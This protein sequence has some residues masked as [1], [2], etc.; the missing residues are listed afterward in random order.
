M[1]NHSDRSRKHFLRLKLTLAAALSLLILGWL[2]WHA[3]YDYRY[4]DAQLPAISRMEI[5]R[6][7]IVHLDEVL[8]MSAQMAAASGNLD[9]ESRYLG[10]EPQLDQAIK[11]A[12]RLDPNASHGEA[13]AKTESANI[14]LV[15]MEHRAFELVRQGKNAE[16]QRLLSSAE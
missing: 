4:A 11:E 6:A 13:A 16:A 9:W 5:V 10:F 12:L 8:T 14:S 15:A 7:E 3:Y 2:S 1:K